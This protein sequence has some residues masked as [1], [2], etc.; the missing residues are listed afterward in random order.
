LSPA[1]GARTLNV[2][3]VDLAAPVE[4]GEERLPP[5]RPGAEDELWFER[6]QMV[7]WLAPRTLFGAAVEVVVSGAFARF[8][9]KREIEGGLPG[10]WYDATGLESEGELWLDFASDTGDGFSPTYAVAST[11]ARREID[12]GT[13]VLP[14]GRLLVLGGDQVYPAAS[15]QA[16]HDRFLGP[17]SSAFPFAADPDEAPHLFA[18]PGNHDWYDGL[19]SFMRL[20]AQGAW[21]GGWRTAQSRSYFAIRLPGNWWLWGVD[22]QFDSY[23]DAPQLDYFD[24]VGRALSPGDRVILA[25]AKPSWINLPAGGAPSA[26]PQS[27][28]TL[29]YVQRRMI[30]RHGGRLALT[31]TGDLHHYCHYVEEGDEPRERKLTAGGAGAYMSATDPTPERLL[32]PDHERLTTRRGEVVG[33]R[34]VATYPDVEAS[35]RI[36]RG[37]LWPPIVS[38]TPSFGVFTGALYALLAFFIAL[39]LRDGDPDFGDLAGGRGAID[40]VGDAL[41]PLVFAPLLAL[42][43][44]AGLC[45]FAAVEGLP[46]KAAYG[47]VH[48]LAHVVALF[49]VTVLVLGWLA[50]DGADPPSAFLCELIV[51]AAAFATGFLYAPVAFAAYLF[52]AVRIDGR[53][54][55]NEV[56]AA[57]SRGAGSGYK[58]V[59]RL[60]VAA[61]A[62]EIHPIAIDGIPRRF[63]P[64]ATAPGLG[65]EAEWFDSSTLRHRLVPDPEAPFEV[66]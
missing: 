10:C 12:V 45:R 63:P 7:Q 53:A 43:L 24:A 55:A 35:R 5:P 8:A 23:I 59:L 14:R 22:T 56:Y 46:R 6:R 64:L 17:Y 32:L 28:R 66:R 29:A 13:A 61:D 36:A 26:A 25:T 49:A 62:V 31:L 20:F 37:V 30:E 65:D 47:L 60:R 54:H 39:A 38:H 40:L 3:R 1:P 41:G 18:L 15:W 51:V 16:Y 58:H 44:L 52:A 33:Y 21:I 11:L 19:T 2:E 57:Q 42:A 27:W 9:D 50:G 48:W 4:A 34:R